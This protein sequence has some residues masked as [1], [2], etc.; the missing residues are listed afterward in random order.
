MSL[1]ADR[2]SWEVD[3]WREKFEDCCAKLHGLEHKYE[4]HVARLEQTVAWLTVRL[5]ESETKV[6]AE[7]D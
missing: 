7:K 6:V 2:Y 1:T 3:E 5:Q 4:I